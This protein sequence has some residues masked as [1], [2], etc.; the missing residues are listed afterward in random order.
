MV[1]NNKKYLFLDVDGVMLDVRKSLLRKT[2]IDKTPQFLYYAVNTLNNLDVDVIVLISTW[3]FHYN[4]DEMNIIF[5]NNGINKSISDYI[6]TPEPDEHFFITVKDKAT[7]IKEYIEK[8]DIKNFLVI[9]DS[10]E[11]V[12]PFP[13]NSIKPEPYVGLNDNHFTLANSILNLNILY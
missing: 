8:N 6:E 1:I 10:N 7:L 3:R 5:K 12:K 11:C 2:D 9:D 4:I 13:N